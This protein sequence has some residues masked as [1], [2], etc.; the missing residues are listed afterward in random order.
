M[1]IKFPCTHIILHLLRQQ[2]AIFGFK[3]FSQRRRH[4]I[5]NLFNVNQPTLARTLCHHSNL[6]PD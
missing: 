3:I 1:V 2:F 6:D 5:Q 4:R